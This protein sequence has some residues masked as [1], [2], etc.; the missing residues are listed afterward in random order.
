MENLSET[1]F[2][3]LYGLRTYKIDREDMFFFLDYD[4]FDSNVV[5][6]CSRKKTQA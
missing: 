1:F 4:A 5:H 6:V 2:Q 3:F